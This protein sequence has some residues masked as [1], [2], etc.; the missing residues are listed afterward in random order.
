M[1]TGREGGVTD[2]GVVVAVLAF[3]VA[4][5]RVKHPFA[6]RIVDDIVKI[7]QAL[8]LH[9]FAQDIHVTVRF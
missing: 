2:T 7:F 6:V 4:F 1:T 5:G 9:K 8:F 3:Q